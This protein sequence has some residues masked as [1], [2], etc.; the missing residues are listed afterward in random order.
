[1]MNLTIDTD[2][3]FNNGICLWQSVMLYSS[4]NASRTDDEEMGDTVIEDRILSFHKDLAGNHNNN[5]NNNNACVNSD[6]IRDLFILCSEMGCE[7]NFSFVLRAL[8]EPNNKNNNNNNKI[9][10][11]KLALVFAG[12]AAVCHKK[13]R[14]F[15]DAFMDT[16]FK[17]FPLDENNNNNNEKFLCHYYTLSSILFS[18]CPVLPI[19]QQQ[20]GH[21]VFSFSHKTAIKKY[22][23]ELGDACALK[24]QPPRLLYRNMTSASNFTTNDPFL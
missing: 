11:S 5:N 24:V 7:N 4:S 23:I 13:T 6:E 9:L 3:S 15:F 2:S 10:K 18:W 22:L 20:Q 14:W 21:T 1:M 19:L 8:L 12:W 16:I 17:N